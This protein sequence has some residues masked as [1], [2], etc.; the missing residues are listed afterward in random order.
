MG[1]PLNPPQRYAEKK[2]RSA[3]GR[4]YPRMNP[5]IYESFALIHGPLLFPGIPEKILLFLGVIHKKALHLPLKSNKKK[6]TMKRN[7]FA[8]FYFYFYFYFS[9]GKGRNLYVR[10]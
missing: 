5:P 7:F 8:Y 9:E 6:K 3:N 1:E 2:K 4:E 10:S